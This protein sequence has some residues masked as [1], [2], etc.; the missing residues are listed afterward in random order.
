M[1]PQLR[2]DIVA[3]ALMCA[4][5]YITE[6]EMMAVRINGLA[7]YSPHG[8]DDIPTVLQQLT[9]IPQLLR[10]AQQALINLAATLPIHG[11]EYT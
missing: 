5:D 9:L 8:W 2:A 3:G 10:D 11:L 1:T 4:P 7:E 6:A